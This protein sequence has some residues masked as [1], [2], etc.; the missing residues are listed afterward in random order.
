MYDGSGV[1]TNACGSALALTPAAVCLRALSATT[2]WQGTIQ[3]RWRQ[4][5]SNKK[6]TRVA[7]KEADSNELP[8]HDN[9]VAAKIEL[10]ERD[11]SHSPASTT[12]GDGVPTSELLAAIHGLTATNARLEATLS[13]LL[14]GNLSASSIQSNSPILAGANGT[15]DSSTAAPLKSTGTRVPAT[16]VTIMTDAEGRSWPDHLDANATPAQFDHAA[17][18]ESSNTASLAQRLQ[19]TRE[20]NLDWE[21]WR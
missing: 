17:S 6:R 3:L 12:A 8:S 21:R 9:S 20:R 19:A 14:A 16:H 7:R 11:V 18:G 5:T 13:A 10:Q 2:Y 4:A 1:R 15:V